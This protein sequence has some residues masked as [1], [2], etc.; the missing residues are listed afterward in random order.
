MHWHIVAAAVSLAALFF[1]AATAAPALEE[2]EKEV[3]FYR[4]TWG[5]LPAAKIRIELDESGGEYRGRIAIETEGL[6]HF[7]TR[8]RADANVEGRLEDGGTALPRLYEA[9]YDLRKWHARR[10]EMRFVPD[11]GALVAER[12]AGDT[13]HKPELAEEFRRNVLDP[14]SA[15]AVIREV[16][17]R[18]PPEPGRA[19]TLPVYDGARRF[20][21]A[22]TLAARGGDSLLHL[23]LLLS[24]RAGFKGESSDEGDP[25]ITPRPAEATVADDGRYILR[26]FTVS[27]FFLP[28]TVSFDHVCASFAECGELKR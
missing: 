9:R 6:A 10:V 27:I 17:R 8:F 22:T 16:L 24:P 19:F 20:D 11:D 14:F 7:L 15:V 13:N 26:S 4:A 12:G 23:K 2:K 5:G 21:V 28:F 25:D 18:E 3:V 1:D